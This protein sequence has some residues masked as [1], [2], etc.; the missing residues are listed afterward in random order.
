VGIER[1]WLSIAAFEGGRVAVV[2]VFERCSQVRDM[3]GDLGA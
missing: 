1:D 3:G 2:K